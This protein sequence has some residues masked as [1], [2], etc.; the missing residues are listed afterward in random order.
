MVEDS[1]LRHMR[2]PD[3]SRERE[4]SPSALLMDFEAMYLRRAC[5]ELYAYNGNELAGAYAEYLHDRIQ[6]HGNAHC[7]VFAHTETAVETLRTAIEECSL[8]YE[9]LEEGLDEKVRS[10]GRQLETRVGGRP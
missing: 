2:Q 6:E 7:Y 1:Q 10:M 5:D 9:C 4:S 8:T 3:T